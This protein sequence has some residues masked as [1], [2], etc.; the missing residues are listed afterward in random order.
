MGKPQRSKYSPPARKK[1]GRASLVSFISFYLLG[2]NKTIQ[3]PSQVPG[4]ANL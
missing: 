4:D 3:P 2:W 1:A